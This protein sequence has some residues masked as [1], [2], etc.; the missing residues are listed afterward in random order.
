[1]L[2]EA[3]ERQPRGDEN[4][5]KPYDL[6]LEQTAMTIQT[7]GLDERLNRCQFY[8]QIVLTTVS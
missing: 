5:D 1:M 2:F 3:I 8:R 7:R 4:Y 6:E